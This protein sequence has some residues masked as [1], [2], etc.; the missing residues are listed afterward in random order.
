VRHVHLSHLHIPRRHALQH[1]RRGAEARLLTSVVATAALAPM[2]AEPSVRAEQVSQLVL[3]E[4]AEVVDARDDW[5]RVRA[6]LDGYD[7]WIH[8]GYLAEVS[9][10][11]AERWRA[12]AL[13]WSDGAALE[14]GGAA[15]RL[16]LRA[17]VALEGDGVRLPD[18][19]CARLTAGRIRP[20]ADSTAD[21][22]RTPVEE[23]AAH[24]FLGAP[25]QWG[26]VT[27]W[28]A[29]CSGLV[30]TAFLARGVRL[31]RDSSQQAALGTAVP[32]EDVRPGDL[33]FFRSESGGAAITHVALAAAADTL[34]HATLACGGAVREAWGPGTRAF[35]LRGRLV[36]ARRISP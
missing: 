27:P 8:R 10:T 6:A 36:A 15:V 28:G 29:D 32:L 9:D 2:L 11:A 30:Q 22:R 12:E 4:T 3:G 26:G 23:W 24:H 33:L 17:R 19:R 21:A 14:L 18:G 34:V 20:V 1:L 35:P 16:P 13:G 7:G 5:R 31:P 25:Y